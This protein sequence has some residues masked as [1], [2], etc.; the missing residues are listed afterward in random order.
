MKKYILILNIIFSL[1]ALILFTSS[2]T[3]N[4]NNDSIIEFVHH[5]ITTPSGTVICPHE[6][7][8]K[9]TNHDSVIYEEEPLYCPGALVLDCTIG[10]CTSAGCSCYSGMTKRCSNVQ[11]CNFCDYNP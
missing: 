3:I 2:S 10:M 4:R 8:L 11:N 6:I 7:I 5:Y 1:A 9:I